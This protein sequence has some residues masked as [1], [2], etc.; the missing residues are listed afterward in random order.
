MLKFLGFLVVLGLAFGLGVYVGQKGPENVLHK[1]KQLG[2]DVVAKTSSVER[3]L[4]VRTGIVNAK[5]RLVQAKS[6]LLDKNYGKAVASLEEAAQSLT[7]AGDAGG[8]E[9][10]GKLRKVAEKLSGVKTEAQALKT[11]LHARVDELVKELDQLL[12]K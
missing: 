8:E 5:E 10:Q 6:E 12:A 3:S 7:K 2:A 11:G 9:L 1:A 4:A